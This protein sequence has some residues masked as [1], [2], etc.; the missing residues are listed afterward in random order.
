MA[1]LGGIFSIPSGRIAWSA[2]G[3]SFSDGR[4]KHDVEAKSPCFRQFRENSNCHAVKIAVIADVE[5]I[6]AFVVNQVENDLP[7]FRLNTPRRV[8]VSEETDLHISTLLAS[9]DYYVCSIYYVHSNLGLWED[10]LVYYRIRTSLNAL[11]IYAAVLF[12]SSSTNS[13]LHLS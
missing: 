3:F 13:P 5:F 9:G 7:Q 12:F 10:G 6:R 2:R 1:N 8:A 11:W 4:Y